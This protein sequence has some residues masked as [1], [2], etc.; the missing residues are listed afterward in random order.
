MFEEAGVTHTFPKT[1]S[2][3]P[4]VA[5]VKKETAKKSG[6]WG[7]SSTEASK[8]DASGA[9]ADAWGDG[10]GM[11]SIMRFAILFLFTQVVMYFVKSYFGYNGPADET[12]V[13][14]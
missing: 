9:Q 6:G 5:A 10:S 14:E 2:T 7:P 1:T 11:G 13:E 4:D 12:T 3:K 8:K